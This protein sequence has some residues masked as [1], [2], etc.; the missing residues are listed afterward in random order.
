MS[1]SFPPDEGPDPYE[2]QDLEGLLS[3]SNS[4]YP[5]GLRPVA[6]TLDA[7]RAAPMRAELGGEA[8]A[9]ADFRAIVLGARSGAAWSSAGSGDG[10]TLILQ[11]EAAVVTPRPVQG[12]HRR[13]APRRGTWPVKALAGVAAAAVVVVG[14]TA[15]MGTLPGI[16]HFR[17]SADPSAKT[18]ST[19]G[20]HSGPNGVAEGAS[21]EATHPSPA[22]STP[23]ADAPSQLCRN[24]YVN[25]PMSKSDRNALYQQLVELAAPMNVK[26]YCMRFLDVYDRP[27][28]QGSENPG[29]YGPPLR[30]GPVNQN[31]QGKSGSGKT[32]NQN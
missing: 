24:F 21:A 1:G 10:R 16:G 28:D 30:D 11:A 27:A 7:L 2:G 13:R 3:G 4:Y 32:Q 22:G 26:P 29:M 8:A 19:Y 5:A 6:Q 25:H 17:P 12:R 23:S 14:V 15:L 18:A 9:R 31:G 20:A